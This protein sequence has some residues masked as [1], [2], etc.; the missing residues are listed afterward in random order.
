MN[1]FNFYEYAYYGTNEYENEMI[2]I[3]TFVLVEM[4]NWYK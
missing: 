1:H 4:L 2:A 3:N